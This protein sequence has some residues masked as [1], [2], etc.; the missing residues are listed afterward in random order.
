MGKFSG[1][2]ETITKELDNFTDK[3]VIALGLDINEGLVQITPKITSWAANNWIPN[4][5]EPFRSTVGSPDNPSA[6][7]SVR[8]AAIASIVS[9]YSFKKGPLFIS[10]NVDYIEPL[11]N[12][13]TNKAPLGFVQLTVVEK[14]DRASKFR[15][16]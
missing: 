6:G 11:N 1:I 12:G 7:A 4:V 9:N 5:G 10:N 14:V 15:L 2:V 16:A 8:T 13:R 3:E